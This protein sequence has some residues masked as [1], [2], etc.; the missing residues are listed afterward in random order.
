M[1]KILK[2]KEEARKISK[3]SKL[4][5]KDALVLI[6]KENQFSDWK[7]YK[8]SIDTYWYQ[9]SSPFLNHWFVKHSEAFEFKAKSGGYLLTYKGQYF[10]ASKEYIE[11]LGLDPDDSVWEAINYDVSSSAALQKFNDYYQGSLK[12]KS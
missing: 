7:S 2:A 1:N 9:S 8:D 10:I 6:A 4:K 11:F 5:L 12:D 3:K